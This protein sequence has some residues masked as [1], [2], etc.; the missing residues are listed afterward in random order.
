MF[1]LISLIQSGGWTILPIL[2]ASIATVALIFDSAWTLGK[3]R[4]RFE[5]FQLNPKAPS[6]M[7]GD[8]A[9]AV[10]TL[11]GYRFAHPQA[12]AEEIRAYAEL[13]FGPLDRKIG[14]L[15]TIAAIAPLLG[16][17]GTV[18][19]MIHN[20]SV[21]ASTRP[22]NPLAQLSAGISEA[23][24]ATAG[25]LVV[26]IVAALAFH[27]LTNR[28][29]ALMNWVLGVLTESAPERAPKGARGPEEVPFGS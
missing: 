16:L 2:L 10:T 20:F 24:V 18:S 19:G 13:A 22:T 11:L 1:R 8:R 17:I 6:L 28:I 3:S 15:N 29:D 21:V 12:K 27:T 4:K 9:D 5:A 23:L 14:W 26:A 25:G 7:P